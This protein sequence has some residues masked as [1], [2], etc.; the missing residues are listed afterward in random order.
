M[1]LDAVLDGLEYKVYGKAPRLG[2]IS[3]DSRRVK[4]GDLFVAMVGQKFDGH[5]FVHE[6]RERGA[7]CVLV[8]RRFPTST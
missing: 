6:A 1:Q 3:Y 4:P 5:D 7:A 2:G 8:E